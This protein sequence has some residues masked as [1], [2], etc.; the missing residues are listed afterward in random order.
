MALR[1]CLSKALL[2]NIK[3]QLRSEDMTNSIFRGLDFNIVNI[4]VILGDF[5]TIFAYKIFNI[6]FETTK[7]VTKMHIMGRITKA[8]IDMKIFE[9]FLSK[10]GKF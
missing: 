10:L 5:F 1:K 9:I 4:G 6:D 7:I 3:I 2:G 8:I